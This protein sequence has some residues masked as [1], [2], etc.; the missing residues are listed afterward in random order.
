MYQVKNKTFKSYN[1]AVNNALMKGAAITDDSG[2]EI[3]ALRVTDR[4]I[5]H[6]VNY[7]VQNI[8]QRGVELCSVAQ[9][10]RTTAEGAQLRDV[11]KPGEAQQPRRQAQRPQPQQFTI[12]F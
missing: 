2:R 4:V 3:P 12:N 7:S 8:T 1:A 9:G 11:R 5:L 10:Y 6:G